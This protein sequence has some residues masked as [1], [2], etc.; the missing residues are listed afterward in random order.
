MRMDGGLRRRQVKAGPA[1]AGF[2]FRVGREQLGAA[3]DAVVGT[4]FMV[5][6]ERAAER[7][8]GALFVS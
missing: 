5:A 7:G 4:I 8:L 3:C 2:E 1:A 6:I